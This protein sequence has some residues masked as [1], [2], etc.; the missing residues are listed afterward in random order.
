MV[1]CGESFH[2]SVTEVWIMR[3]VFVFATVVIALLLGIVAA[4]SESHLLIRALIVG[5]IPAMWG[6]S[7]LIE[8]VT[9]RDMWDFSAPYQ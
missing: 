4:A 8:R 6:V 9:G 5:Y 3:A 7:H 2:R 1:R